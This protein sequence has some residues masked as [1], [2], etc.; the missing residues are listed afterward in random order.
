M[1]RQVRLHRERL[2]AGRCLRCPS[3]V[4]TINPQTG[5][6]FSFCL[7]CRIR[8]AAWCYERR[9]RLGYVKRESI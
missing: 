3:P 6:R 7:P 5:R 1:T 2:A 4:T 8:Y 9:R